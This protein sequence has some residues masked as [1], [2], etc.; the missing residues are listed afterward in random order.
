MPHCGVKNAD[1]YL[2]DFKEA[3]KILFNLF[4]FWPAYGLQKDTLFG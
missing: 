4:E 2:F 1:G 3:A